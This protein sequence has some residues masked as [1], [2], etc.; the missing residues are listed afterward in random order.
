[1][2]AV[3]AIPTLEAYTKRLSYQSQVNIEA[4]IRDLAQEEK[5]DGSAMKKQVEDLQE[6]VRKLEDRV[7]MLAAQAE[8]AKTES[9]E[10]G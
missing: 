7:E 9:D 1:M 6:K 10:N 2:D 3:E 5:V 8:T 4:L